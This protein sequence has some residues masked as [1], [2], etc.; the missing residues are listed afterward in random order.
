MDSI[1]DR[2]SLGERG[3]DA[4]ASF[5]ETRGH[6]VIARRF[7]TQQGE[8]DLI[9]QRGSHLYFVEVKVRRHH[10][11]E[12]RYGDGLQAVGPRK[13]RKIVSVSQIFIDRNRLHGLVPHFSVIAIDQHAKAA[14]LHFLPDAFDAT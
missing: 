6:R 11:N 12:F 14:E 2:V 10:H 13:Q 5:L 7:R 3:E 1:D 4:A 9:S 8:I